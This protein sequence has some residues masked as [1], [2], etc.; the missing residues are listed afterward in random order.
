MGKAVFRAMTDIEARSAK[1]LGRARFAPGTFDKRFARNVAG[2]VTERL[3]T[4]KQAVLMWEL[5]HRYRRSIEDEELLEIA[6]KVKEGE[7]APGV[8]PLFE[9]KAAQPPDPN[10]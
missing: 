9:P 4:D 2:Q 6:K 1:A 7:T 3:I 8:L 10:V 5:V